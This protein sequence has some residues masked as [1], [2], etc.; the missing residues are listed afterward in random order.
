MQLKL[1]MEQARSSSAEKAMTRY[2]VIAFCNKCGGMHDTGVSIMLK[3]GPAK[4][5]SICEAYKEKSV[6]QSL[7]NLSNVSITCP[8]TGRGFTQKD[9][10][11]I[12]LVPAE[13]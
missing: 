6:P 8:T 11:Q 10:H 1:G 5:Q 2:T 3:D 12:F 9:D 13:S 4:R 7:A